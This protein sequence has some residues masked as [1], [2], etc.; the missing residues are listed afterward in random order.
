MRLLVDENVDRLLI[1]RLRAEGHE[2]VAV[3]ETRP[4]VPDDAVLA[5]AA[6]EGLVLLTADKDFGQLVV[7]QRR[8]H[9]GMALVRLPELSRADAAERVVAAIRA[10][11]ARFAGAF[12]IIGPHAVRVR[13]SP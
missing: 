9:A 5:W 11:G 2:V 10:H 1:E 4:G 8:A 7:Q 12:V 6:R 13:R 3:R